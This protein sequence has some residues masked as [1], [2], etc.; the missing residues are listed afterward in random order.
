M[1]TKKRWSQATA[2][3]LCSFVVQLCFAQDGPTVAQPGDPQRWYDHDSTENDYYLTLKKEAEAVYQEAKTNCRS[4]E[5]S[6]RAACLKDAQ[7]QYRQ[8]LQEAKSTA[9]HAGQ[10]DK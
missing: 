5:K 7:T 10:R 2:A 8:D 9:W 6:D 3:A 4:L 1:L